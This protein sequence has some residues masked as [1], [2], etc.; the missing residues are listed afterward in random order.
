MRMW[1]GCGAACPP[2]GS[3]RRATAHRPVRFVSI[4]VSA[5][6]P[7]YDSGR[8][9]HALAGLGR[10]VDFES[11][12]RAVEVLD[13]LDQ[14]AVTIGIVVGE[15]LVVVFSEAMLVERLGFGIVGGRAGR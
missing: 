6:C 10:P 3:P 13:R 2:S 12:N 7:P 9:E 1:R 11:L 15:A 5:F 8:A 14:R 4:R